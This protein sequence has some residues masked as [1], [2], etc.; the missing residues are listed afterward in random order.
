MTESMLSAGLIC[1]L[2][3]EV[4]T[5]FGLATREALDGAPVF[6]LLFVCPVTAEPPTDREVPIFRD[7]ISCTKRLLKSVLFG[8][9]LRNAGP[10]IKVHHD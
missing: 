8:A 1:L 3:L 4:D 9:L 7:L 10:Y 5:E 6:S 2:T